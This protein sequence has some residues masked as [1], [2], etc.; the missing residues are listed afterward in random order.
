DAPNDRQA[1]ADLARLVWR[2]LGPHLPADL[3]TIY[4]APDGELT[5]L[6]WGA[7]PGSKPGSVLLEEV[8]I[9]LLPHALFLLNRL[10]HPPLRRPPGGG[11]LAAGD[12]DY[13]SAAPAVA[14]RRGLELLGIAPAPQTK[15][16]TWSALPGTARE[17]LLVAALARKALGTKPRE[18][19]GSA[20]ST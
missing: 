6:P 4:P 17:R 15:A 14:A 3:H 10:A 7:L 8:A 13:T 1:A 19:F 16:V 11:V 18:R 9:A 20:A 12:V 5:R 2:P